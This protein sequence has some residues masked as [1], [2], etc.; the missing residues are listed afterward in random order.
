[1]EGQIR[2]RKILHAKDCKDV[3]TQL[4]ATRTANDRTIEVIASS[5]IFECVKN[6]E[7]NGA[8]L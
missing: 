4:S 7:T 5:N 8:K 2:I 3:V 6:S 1:M